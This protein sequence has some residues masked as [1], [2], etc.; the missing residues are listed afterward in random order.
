MTMMLVANI[1]VVHGKRQYFFIVNAKVLQA[2]LT[3][4]N[5][6]TAG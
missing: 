6:F 1:S 2:T 3:G 5:S 4:T